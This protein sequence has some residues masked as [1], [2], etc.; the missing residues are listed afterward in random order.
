MSDETHPVVIVWMITTGFLR[1]AS[2]VFAVQ[3]L[4]PGAVAPARCEGR[5]YGCGSTGSGSWSSA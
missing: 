1:V 4:F 2:R 5:V 3:S